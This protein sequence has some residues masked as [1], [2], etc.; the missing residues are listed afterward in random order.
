M[1]IEV[2]TKE[3]VAVKNGISVSTVENWAAAG[4]LFPIKFGGKLFYSTDPKVLEQ[5]NASASIL[6]FV[7]FTH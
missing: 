1:R 5:K 2:F 4:K 3:T 7:E 6:H